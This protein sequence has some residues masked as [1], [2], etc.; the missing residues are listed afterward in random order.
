MKTSTVLS[1]FAAV[2]L[3]A[4]TAAGIS[5]SAD[6]LPGSTD[7]TATVTPAA[8]PWSGEFVMPT[9]EELRSRLTPLQYDVTQEE[10]T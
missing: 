9:E 6:A 7:N 4:V 1:A 10:D 3:A 5:M 8:A 2:T